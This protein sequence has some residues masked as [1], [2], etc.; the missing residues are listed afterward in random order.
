MKGNL[1]L[2]PSAEKGKGGGHLS[3]C[4]KLTNDLR[5]MGW[6]AFLYLPY[7][8]DT[9]KFVKLFKSLNFD[10]SCLVFNEEIT[11][12]TEKLSESYKF[13]ILDRFKT[14]IDELTRWKKISPV[15]GI[16]DGGKHRDKFDFLID[17]LIPQGFI[18]PEANITSPALILNKNFTTED[19]EE[20]GGRKDLKILVTFGQEDAANLGLKTLKKI[21]SLKIK[22]PIEITLLKGNL[23]KTNITFDIPEY[24]K[25]IESIPNLSQHLCEYDLVIT[26][27]G[28][29]AYEAAF[30]GVPVLLAH[31]TNYHRKLAKAAGF[32]EFNKIHD[33]I[34]KFNHGVHGEHGGRMNFR[35]INSVKLRDLRG[36]FSNNNSIAELV[37]TFSPV[38]NRSCPVCGAETG[39]N[40]SRLSD[41]TYR[42][43]GKCAVIYM[44]RIT[45]PPIEYEK[46]YFFENYKKQYG[47]TYLED[48]ENIKNS[49]KNRLK[50]IKTLLPLCASAPLRDETRLPSLLDIGCAYGPFLKAAQEE[51]FAPFGIDPA[52]DAVRYVQQELKIPAIQ[53]FF[54][55]TELTNQGN[56]TYDVVTLWFVIEHF[57]NCVTVLKEISRLLKPGGILAF[58]TPSY[59][60]ISG[61]SNLKKFLSQS[62]ADHFTI[63]SPKMC[64]KALLLAGFKVKKISV[65]GHHPQRFPVLGKF[66]KNKNSP[67]YFLLM[68]ISKLFGLG[69]TFEVYSIKLNEEFNHKTHESVPAAR[70]RT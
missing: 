66:A 10:Q 26:H 48:F 51:G 8:T 11:I 50:I 6:N 7:G 4:I 24:V 68:A 54:P 43:C 17:I 56:K 70:S 53:G 9:G 65:V 2:V 63:W 22:N 25:I 18:K 39:K 1:I 58:S 69:D 40:L 55:N 60:G 35:T 64:K 52:E 45:E 36:S 27:Y 31:P 13:I 59:S 21:L 62:P 5:K 61:S 49:G 15:I 32:L 28:L 41:R 12:K 33:L 67:V 46:E 14:P 23:N 16:D 38:V 57:T 34:K 42:R 37:N 29:T 3:R 30:A 20:H 44:D 19:T 47:K